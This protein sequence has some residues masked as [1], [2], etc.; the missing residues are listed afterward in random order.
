MET[1]GAVTTVEGAW[2]FT[3]VCSPGTHGSDLQ[4]TDVPVNEPY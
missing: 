2:L 4:L 1:F 3:T